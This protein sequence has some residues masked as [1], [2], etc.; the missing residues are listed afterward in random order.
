MIKKTI[1]PAFAV[2]A[3]M[4]A[5]GCSSGTSAHS[6]AAAPPAPE[7]TSVVAAPTTSAAPA[8]A[9]VI[10]DACTLLTQR[11]A[12]ALAGVKLRSGDGT[13]ASGPTDIATC[14]W[15]SPP[16]GSSGSVQVFAQLSTPRAL[17]IDRAIHH[18]FRSVAG[19]ADQTL[20]EPENSAIF[21]HKGQLWVYV[22]VP[23]GATPKKLERA[24]TE[25]AARLA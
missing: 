14:N 13:R 11:E 6:P 10:P 20:E 7:A 24:A 23:Y 9:P 5:A 22:S 16:T 8:P 21:V 18:R 2:A 17:G 1:L 25:I 12:Q 19:I 3:A 15:D 4:T